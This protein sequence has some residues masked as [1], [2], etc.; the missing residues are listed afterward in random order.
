[1]TETAQQKTVEDLAMKHCAPKAIVKLG[2]YSDV[3]ITRFLGIDIEQNVLCE[4]IDR[5]DKLFV[6]D[7][8]ESTIV[9]YSSHMVFNI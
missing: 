1:M 2:G 8:D 6:K 4:A 3:T 5:L 7:P 9:P